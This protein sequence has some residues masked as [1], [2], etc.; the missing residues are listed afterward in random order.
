MWNVRAK[1]GPE[2]DQLW[3]REGKLERIWETRINDTVMLKV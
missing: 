3:L 2:S 1:S